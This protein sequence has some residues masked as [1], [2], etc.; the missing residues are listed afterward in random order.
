[1]AF[2]EERL[3]PRVTQGVEFIREVPGRAM[4]R[5]P[6]GKLMQNFTGHTSVTRA[7]MNHGGLTPAQYQALLDCWYIVMFTPYEGLRVRDW[8]DY[9]ATLLNSAATLLDGSTT[10]LQLQRKH[11]FG[12]V[13]FLRDIKKPCA[14]PVVQLYRTRSGVTSAIASTVDTTTG[15][16]T[17]SG[18][19]SGDAYSWEGQFDL[20]MTFSSNTWGARLEAKNLTV[21]GDINMEECL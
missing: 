13:T 5:Q 8:S 3:D 12:T 1:M 20:P 10:Q 17:M 15:I 11:V 7:N 21:A 9:R 14:A 6:S 4:T 19:A 16:A 2:L 18:H